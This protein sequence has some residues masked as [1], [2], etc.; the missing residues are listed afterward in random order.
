MKARL[1]NLFWTVVLLLVVIGFIYA[2]FPSHPDA[3]AQKALAETRL[4]L[5]QQGFKTDL[6]DF[7]LS[8][9]PEMRA[10]ET[11]L[12]NTVQYRFAG[13]YPD[14]PNLMQPV[15]NNSAIVVWKLDSLKRELRSS[16]DDSDQLSCGRSEPQSVSSAAAS[17]DDG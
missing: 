10:R 5:R 16:P 4:A 17:L 12:T 9:P 14:H 2:V 7:D 6:A 13:A 8:T 1:A 3:A 11:I 15:G